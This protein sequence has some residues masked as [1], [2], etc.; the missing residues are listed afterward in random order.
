[1][2]EKTYLTKK[3]KF[4]FAAGGFG[5]NLIIGTV[6]SYLLF[7]F[8]DIAAIGYA[9][10][11]I[12]MLVARIFDAFNDPIMGVIADRTRT[13]YGKL[14]PYLLAAPIPLGIVT[15]LLFIVPGGSQA[16]RIAYAAI[17][18]ILWG[19]I[20]TMGDIPFWGIAS[21]LTPNPKERVGFITFSRLF[22]SIGGALPYLTLPIASA[23]FGDGSRES[24]LAIGLFAGIVGGGLFLLTFFGT[25]ERGES[26]SKAPSVKECFTYLFRN[27]PLLI[28]VLANVLGFGRAILTTAGMYIA[29]YLV[30]GVPAFLSGMST[31]T[32][33]TVML[34][35]FAVAGFL[36]MIFTP[37]LTKR[38]NYRIIQ[39]SCCVV[40]IVGNVVFLLLGLTWGYNF[41]MILAVQIVLGMAYGLTSNV[42]YAMIA[43]SVDYLE[44]KEGRRTEGVSIS[45]QTFM[46]KMMSALQ[47]FVIPL[48]L[49]AVGFV[50]K[51][52]GA[53]EY[54]VQSPEALKGFFLVLC[55]LPIVCWLVSGIVFFFYDFVGEKRDNIYR[56]LTERRTNATE[57]AE[58]LEAQA[59]PAE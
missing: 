49:S 55:I 14:R 59:T 50:E 8:T 51:A 22:H 35:G 44:W 2:E 57:V 4:S 16:A 10:A 1:M 30:V 19:I 24:Y 45:M 54:P 21:A 12:I 29:T 38:F 5:Q 48:V 9:A 25:E 27:K 43:E 17:F 20:Y 47:F 18:Y 58:P 39:L 6:N 7:F 33:N 13:K 36:A 31:S 15:C 53:K 56:E 32:I 52:E 3:N 41:W 26:D 40:G 46:N 23:I 11:S 37:K 42:N 28:V 34:V